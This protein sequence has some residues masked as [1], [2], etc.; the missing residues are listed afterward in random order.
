MKLKKAQAWGFDLVIGLFIFTFVIVVFYLYALNYTSDS[1]EAFQVLNQEGELIADSLLSEGSPVDW[2]SG[3]AIRIGI[4]SDDKINETK[5]ERF[6]GLDYEMTKIL[7]NVRYDYYVNF[8]KSLD[9]NGAMIGGI[10][11]VNLNADNVAL[12]RRISSYE[13]EPIT[14]S[15]YL[16]D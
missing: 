13:G 1:E 15:I 10:G 5:L 8:S 16:S 3:N 7:F 2:N 4:L 11:Q 9:V 6:I 14:L 12:V